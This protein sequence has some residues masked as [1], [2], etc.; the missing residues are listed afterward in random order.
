[1]RFT[2][3]RYEELIADLVAEGYDF[4]GYGDPGSEEVILRHDVDLSPERALAMA[5]IEADLGVTSTYFFLL[6]APVYD[7][8]DP[9]HREALWEIESLGHDVGLH[10]DTHRAW[11][12][13]PDRRT[14]SETVTREMAALDRL[15]DGD[16][17]VVSFHI[18]PEWVLDSAF[19]GFTNAYA[20][21]YFSD[22]T[23][24]SDSNQKWRVR[25]PFVDGVPETVQ[26]LVHPGLWE[27]RDRSLDAIVDD[28][29]DR[30][31]HRVDAYLHRL[32]V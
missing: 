28:L 24:L 9:R 17:E 32:G 22:I 13:R 10:F 16:V 27:Q 12:E 21:R 25:R 7:L 30:T 29:S 5:R 6:T 4:V 14:L 3:D 8:L 23:Y 26:L 1:M 2:P 18:P 19:E 31:H 11:E 15:T 20:P